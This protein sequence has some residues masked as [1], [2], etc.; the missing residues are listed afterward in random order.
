[1]RRSDSHGAVRGCT[2]ACSNDTLAAS[3]VFAR[4]A[5]FHGGPL[6]AELLAIDSTVQRIQVERVIIDRSRSTIRHAIV[7]ARRA[8]AQMLP[9]SSIALGAPAVNV[10]RPHVENGSKFTPGKTGVRRDIDYPIKASF[11]G[12]RLHD[13]KYCVPGKVGP[14]FSAVPGHP[15][16][17][18]SCTIRRDASA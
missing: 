10:V 4:I 3:E 18:I 5:C 12:I 11:K 8:A 15:Y 16:S 13:A 1:M 17:E 7:H 9:G 14:L 2:A 6:D